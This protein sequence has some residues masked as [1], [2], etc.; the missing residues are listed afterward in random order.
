MVVREGGNR[1]VI[2]IINYF[3]SY[4][5]SPCHPNNARL[6]TYKEKF[7][8]KSCSTSNKLLKMNEGV[9]NQ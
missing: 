3:L 8:L 4:S 2:S 1:V 6:S 5:E 7:A 9:N